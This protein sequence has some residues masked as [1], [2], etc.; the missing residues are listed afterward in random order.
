MTN[1]Q[2]ITLRLSEVRS[3]LNEVSGLEGDLLTDEIRGEAEALQTEYRDLELKFR[4]ATI[5][6]GEAEAGALGALG[7]GDGQSAEIRGLFRKVSVGGDYLKAAAAGVG[8]SGAAVELASALDAPAVGASGGI[9]IPW[10]VLSPSES[11]ALTD[12]GDL[13]GGVVQRPILQRLFGAGIFDALG[14]RLDAV[15]AGRSEWPLLTGGVDPSHVAEGSAGADPVAAVF[16]TEVLKPKKLTGAYSW[17]HELAAQVAEGESALRRDLG[18]SVKAKM[19]DAALNGDE[20]SNSHE[21]NGFLHK[22]AAPD[23]P[24]AIAQFVDYAGAPSTAVDGVHAGKET[25]VS[26]VLGIDSYQHAASVFQTG[27]GSGE[28]ASEVI[29]RRSGGTMA[30]S[31]IPAKVSATKIQNGNL[32]HAAG[33]NGG[34]ARGDS[35]AALW[36]L[37]VIRDPYSKA[38]QGVILTWITLW[39]FSAAF[40][41]SAYKRIAF[42][43]A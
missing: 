27:S 6:E 34:E 29:K 36:S 8:L 17:T 32:L 14:V 33:P 4:A 5:A 28:S 19:S 20:A 43:L 22:I 31:F 15:P 10:E 26:V 7:N 37:E 41:A 35:V 2:K 23:A 13:A 12:T 1:L 42:K 40:R 9:V 30:S 3:R 38:S 25:E 21:V 16:S 11:R 39:D 18:G 24:T